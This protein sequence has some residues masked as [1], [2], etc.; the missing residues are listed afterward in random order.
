[1]IVEARGK[2][3][4]IGKDCFIAPNATII[5]DVVIGDRCSIWYNV[6]IRGDVFPIRIGD[7]VNIQDGA[8]LHGTYE[9]AGVVLENRVTVGHLAM[10]H[11]CHIGEACLVGMSSIVMDKVKIGDHCL[12]AA[13]SLVVENSQIP[14]KQMVLGRPAKAVRALTDEEVGRLEK[15]ADN[16]LMYKTWYDQK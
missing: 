1:M 3:P 8:V 16:Y 11:G 12:I 2:R 15:S 4:Q 6:V 10:L 14:A 9:R 5:G 13:G 7:E